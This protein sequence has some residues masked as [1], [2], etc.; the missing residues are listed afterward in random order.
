[1]GVYYTIFSTTVFH[2]KTKCK[3]QEKIYMNKLER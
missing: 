3:D 1:M 2:N